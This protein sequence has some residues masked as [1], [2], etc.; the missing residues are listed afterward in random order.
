M[1]EFN[2]KGAHFVDFSRHHEQIRVVAHSR[3]LISIFNLFGLHQD[4]SGLH[5]C[6]L[7]HQLNCSIE[8]PDSPLPV[9]WELPPEKAPSWEPTA[10][11]AKELTESQRLAM[12]SFQV[13]HF[14]W[15]RASASSSSMSSR[16]LSSS[17]T[18]WAAHSSPPGS[19]QLISLFSP[20]DFASLSTSEE[21]LPDSWASF[22]N[23]SMV[24]LS[25]D[26]SL[27]STSSAFIPVSISTSLF[28]P[29]EAL[30][31]L[32]LPSASPLLVITF[33]ASIFNSFSLLLA[34]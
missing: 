13:S 19:S 18:N 21:P 7:N 31:D 8:N 1:M 14:S 15:R 11:C 4:L 6:P 24:L 16:S 28:S 10:T 26:S 17:S 5:L 12:V 27:L 30:P 20:S 2:P 23:F 25:L 34:L 22:S 33:S 9:F 3:G 29:A 32:S